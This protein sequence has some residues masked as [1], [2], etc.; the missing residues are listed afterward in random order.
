MVQHPGQDRRHLRPPR[1]RRRSTSSCDDPD[2]VWARAKGSGRGCSPDGGHRLRLCTGSR[3]PTPRAT[4]G[5]S[6]HTRRLIPMTRGRLADYD[7][8]ADAWTRS[9]DCQS[10]SMAARIPPAEPPDW[11]SSRTDQGSRSL[12]RRR[13]CRR[14]SSRAGGARPRR[15]P[16]AERLD[17]EP[18]GLGPRLLLGHGLALEVRRIGGMPGQSFEDPRQPLGRG[19]VV[20]D[21]RLGGDADD[22]EREPDDG[23]RPVLAGGAVDDHGTVGLADRPQG[24]DDRVRAAVEIAEVVLRPVRVVLALFLRRSGLRP[25]CRGSTWPATDL[26]RRPHV[27]VGLPREAALAGG[28]PGLLGVLGVERVVV[29]RTS[30]SATSGPSP[31]LATS[32]KVRRSTTSVTPRSSTRW[33]TEAGDS[34]WRLSDR[35]SRPAATAPP[36]LVG[37]PPTSRMLSTPS[38]SIHAGTGVV[39]TPTTLTGERVRA[40]T[41]MSRR[42]PLRRAE[43]RRSCP[44]FDPRTHPKFC[45]SPS[46]ER[47]FD[48]SD[49]RSASGEPVAWGYF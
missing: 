16:A 35:I 11:Q 48:S 43:A 7:W 17:E 46:P 34:S 27:A 21:H 47:E 5:R 6:G 41:S 24:G 49:L 25:V 1:G 36:S 42:G 44:R 2:V 45:E 4:P 28:D 14:R 15:P 32:T 40:P 26:R 23:P 19:R 20:G 8:P 12:A 29:D 31:S 39:V 10:S 22:E 38:S 13:R 18:H 37:S 30:G 33:R 3:S 9:L